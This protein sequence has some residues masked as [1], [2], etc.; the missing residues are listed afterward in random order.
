MQLVPR[1]STS[2]EKILRAPGSLLHVGFQDAADGA[3]HQATTYFSAVSSIPHTVVVAPSCAAEAEALMF[4]AIR[5]QVEERKAGK[6]GESVVFFVGREGY[7]VD[8]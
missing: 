2:L 3:S 6:D 8:G 7:P 4:E 5:R 1:R